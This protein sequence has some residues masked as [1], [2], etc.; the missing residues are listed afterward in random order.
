MFEKIVYTR[1]H[2]FFIKFQYGFR[3]NDTTSH[4]IIDAM[5]YIYNSLDKG[6]FHRSKR[7][8]DTVSHDIF[9]DKLKH[10]GKWGIALKWFT[11]FLKDRT[12]NNSFQLTKLISPSI[13]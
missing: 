4:A 5:E 9:L 12:G 2:H 13:I 1:L 3:K 8:F 6:N 10:Y 7:A 11:P